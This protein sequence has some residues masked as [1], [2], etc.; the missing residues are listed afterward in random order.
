MVSLS[1]HVLEK[2]KENK[3]FYFPIP[4]CK[5]SFHS[6]CMKENEEFVVYFSR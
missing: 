2:K 1:S 5:I 4:D 3:I 6:C